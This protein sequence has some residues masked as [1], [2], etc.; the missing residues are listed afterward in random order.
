MTDIDIQSLKLA[1]VELPDFHPEAPGADTIYGFLV[2]VS[3]E[4]ILVDTG[5]G[6]GND[7]IDRLYRPERVDLRRALAE[8]GAS[9]D[10][11][12]GIVNSH[13]HFDHCGNNQ[14]FPGVPIYVQRAELDAA[15]QPHYTVPEWVEFA[16]ANYV[17]VDGS[18][19]ISPHLELVSTPGHTPG[20]QSL[21]VRSGDRLDVIVAQAAYAAAE[22]EAFRAVPSD[23]ST[24]EAYIHSNATWSRD[25]YVDSLRTLHG[26]RP[27]R[28]FF[29]HDPTAWEEQRAAT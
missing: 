26:L 22:F 11:I 10:E 4:C 1:R 15:A 14:L 5:V 19:S 27:S 6:T 17:T 8:V 25:P 18:H 7:V 2:R 28:A 9:V 23:D 29:S 24:L 12:T 21:L 20:H 3:R 16:G 13:L